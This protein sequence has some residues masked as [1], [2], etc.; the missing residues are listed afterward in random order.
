[1]ACV[2]TVCVREARTRSWSPC[3]RATL[4]CPWLPVPKRACAGEPPETRRHVT[5][6]RRPATRALMAR[7]K[8]RHETGQAGRIARHHTRRGLGIL[9]G[10]LS[11][12]DRLVQDG[13]GAGR[14]RRRRLRLPRCRG[15]PRHR[16]C[17]SGEDAFPSGVGRRLAVLARVRRCRHGQGRMGTTMRDAVATPRDAARRSGLPTRHGTWRHGRSQSQSTEKVQR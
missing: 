12:A 9:T 15:G 13:L 4:R 10:G 17:S 6:A 8:Q 2:V 16:G 1:M 5:C 3:P 7:N 11:K 14:S